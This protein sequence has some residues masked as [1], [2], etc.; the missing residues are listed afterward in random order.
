MEDTC[1]RA[2]H[3]TSHP[4]EATPDERITSPR[5]EEEIAHA[6]LDPGTPGRK[7]IGQSVAHRGD[8]ELVPSLFLAQR[9][10]N[11]Q[12]PPAVVVRVV[13]SSKLRWHKY[14][15]PFSGKRSPVPPRRALRILPSQGSISSTTTTVAPALLPAAPSTNSLA[16]RQNCRYTYTFVPT[17]SKRLSD[18]TSPHP[19]Y[20]AMIS[21]PRNPARDHRSQA[22]VTSR[23]SL[24]SSIFLCILKS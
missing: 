16:D 22:N 18:K 10:H 19:S 6:R 7:K 9:A 12:H 23:S 4:H 17:E 11:L 15:R 5:N 1:R 13:E 21:Y 14:S 2:R 3:E 24:A 20:A 8:P